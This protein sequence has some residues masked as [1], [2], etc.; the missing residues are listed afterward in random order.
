MLKLVFLARANPSTTG[1]LRAIGARR[2][3]RIGGEKEETAQLNKHGSLTRLF[4]STVPPLSPIRNLNFPPGGCST[5][6]L[7]GPGLQQ[8]SLE[9]ISQN[10]SF[11]L[12]GISLI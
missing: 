6:P 9:R 8:I 4:A 12:K 7:P 10:W 11:V 1:G 3:G 2:D 5:K